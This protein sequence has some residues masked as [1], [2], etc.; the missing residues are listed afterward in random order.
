M[1]WG[2][3][4]INVPPNRFSGNVKTHCPECHGRRSDRRDKSLS[5]NLETGMFKCHYCGYSGCA[6]GG[7][8]QPGQPPSRLPIETPRIAQ[9]KLPHARP[10]VPYSEKLK[11]WFIQ[12]GISPETAERAGVTEGPEWMPQQGKQCNTVQFNYYLDRQLVNTKFRTGRKEFKL[13]AG[14]RLVPWN[15]DEIK[16]TPECVICEGGMDAL[17]FLEIGRTDAISVPNGASA[18]LSYLDDFIESHFEGK[19]TIYIAVDTDEK[20]LVLRNELLRRFGTDK[21]RVLA[22]GEGCKDA[23]DHLV[24]H[25]ADSLR[26]LIESAAEVPVEGVFSVT[27]FEA[28]QDHLFTRGLQPGRTLG[29]EGL[30]ELVSFETRRLCIVTGVPGSGKSEFIDEMAE[31]LNRR[32][33]WKWGFFSPENAPLELHA[34]KIISKLTGEAFG[35]ATMR[36]ADYEEAKDYMR[37]NFFFISPERYE[38]DGILD[39]AQ[40]LVSRRG[41][42]ALVIDPYNRLSK[43]FRISELQYISEILDKLYRF[44]VQHNVLVILMAHPRKVFQDGKERM[45]TLYDCSG[46]A[47]FYNKTDFG[48]IVHRNRESGVVEI[49]VQKV[50]F[51]HLGRGGKV[52]LLY[53]ERNGRYLPQPP[54]GLPPL[55]DNSNHL[56]AAVGESITPRGDAL[57]DE[58]LNPMRPELF[59]SLP[60]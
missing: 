8:S 19:E 51:R 16:T 17:S 42:N 21:C 55:W 46:S 24:A 31:R 44:A 12:R 48:I 27:D 7:S 13:C 20:G 10:K 59:E 3:L 52:R 45:P 23:N 28:E 25:G 4:V 36:R 1:R 26:R 29:I 11:A 37:G 34:S 2:E 6:K 5:C 14:A 57:A 9:F 43:D 49:H 60:F 32:Y 50:K 58:N 40:H 33:G 53:N 38:I 56:H 47:D 15:I 54:D 18:N 41:I 35:A 30:D 22:Y 39:K